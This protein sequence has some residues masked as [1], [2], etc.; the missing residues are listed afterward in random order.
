[1]SLVLLPLYIVNLPKSHIMQLPSVSLCVCACACACVCVKLLTDS[2]HRIFYR[3][4]LSSFQE[5]T[6]H[7]QGWCVN[8]QMGQGQDHEATVKYSQHAVMSD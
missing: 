6:L 2:C 4:F 3:K 7:C 5:T 8:V 1:M